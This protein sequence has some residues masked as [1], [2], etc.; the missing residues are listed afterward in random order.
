MLLFAVCDDCKND[1]LQIY[2]FINDYYIKG[3]TDIHIVQFE[4]GEDLVEYY[5]EGNTPFDII[6]LDIYMNGKT[7]I[8]AAE[9]LR[10]YDTNCKIIFT[11]SSSD[12]ALESFK[13]FPFNYLVK[14]ISKD[15]FYVSLENAIGGIEENK[16]KSLCVKIGA[17]IQKV[18]FKDILY[19][20]SSAK[21]INIHTTKNK[22]FIFSSKLDDVEK[23]INDKRFIRCH[24]SFLVNMDHI[25][26]VEEYSF[27]LVDNTVISIT[28]RYFASNKKIFYNYL[29]GKANLTNSLERM[30]HL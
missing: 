7:G 9:Q 11:T 28:R 24:K 29:L 12:H 1:R 6:F 25:L 30:D 14:P 17:M 2:D 13:V 3:D 20:E 10:E 16:N 23:Q 8:L 22:N 21:S 27:K 18:F 5:I 26:S 19:I 4:N 15:V